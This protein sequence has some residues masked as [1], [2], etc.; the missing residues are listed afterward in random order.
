MAYTLREVT[1]RANNTAAGMKKIDE[2]WHDITSGK[3][4]VLFDS[5]H[6]FQQGISPISR[7]SNYKGDESGDY[8]LSIL[9]VKADFFREME[10]KV[11]KGLYKK[12]DVSDEGGD[13]GICAG[14]AWKIVWNE[15]KNGQI[16]RAFTTDYES[17]VPA[18]YTKDKKAHCYLYISIQT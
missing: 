17:T 16:K 14:K 9:G 12:Y 4:P 11:E 13:I 6:S 18:K 7:Y 2:L 1:I 10:Q 8:D 3:L 15:Q 5:E